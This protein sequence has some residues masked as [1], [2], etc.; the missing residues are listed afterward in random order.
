MRPELFALLPRDKSDTAKAEA[1]IA[2]GY[3]AV[4][5]L[6][7]RLI[8]WMQD[9]N[10]P[11]ARVLAPFLAGIGKPMEGHILQVLATTDEIWKYWVLECIVGKSMELRRCL[12][13]ELE[14][15]ASNPTD[16]E[17]GEELHSLAQSL[18][19]SAK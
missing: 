13:P 19:K 9:A 5:P 15:I 1:I 12:R 11:V 18:L 3:P 16:G 8:E 10:W 7:P 4:E 14:R 6:L 17:V 2:A